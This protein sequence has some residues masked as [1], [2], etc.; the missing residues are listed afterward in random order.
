MT[1]P[2]VEAVCVGDELSCSA[3]HTVWRVTVDDA[4]AAVLDA[5]WE[6]PDLD[7]VCIFC[8]PA[9]RARAAMSGPLVSAVAPR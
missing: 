6:L 2:E 7:E 8:G 3:G 4:V 5:S 1:A 9:G